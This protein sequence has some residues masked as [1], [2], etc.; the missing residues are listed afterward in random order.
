MD[1]LSI[2]IWEGMSKAQQAEVLAEAMVGLEDTFDLLMGEA[3]DKSGYPMNYGYSSFK[4]SLQPEIEK[5]RNNG[6]ELAE[7]I[8]NGISE[9]VEADYEASERFNGAWREIPEVNFK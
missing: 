4:K 2:N 5:L 3:S 7:R 6:M 1:E 8:Q 9:T